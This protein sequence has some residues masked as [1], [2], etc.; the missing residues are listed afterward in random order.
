MLQFWKDLEVT[1]VAEWPNHEGDSTID[2]A[3]RYKLLKT[4][5]VIAGI[6]RPFLQHLVLSCAR[7]GDDANNITARPTVRAL[8]LPDSTHPARNPARNPTRSPAHIPSVTTRLSR[9]IHDQVSTAFL[10]SMPLRTS[11]SPRLSSQNTS[12]L[13][14]LPS[15]LYSSASITLPTALADQQKTLDRS[16]LVRRLLI[17]QRPFECT[18][19]KGHID[20][21]QL[22]RQ[23][24]VHNHTVKIG[25]DLSGLF[26]KDKALQLCRQ[27][28][29]LRC[30]C[31]QHG[32][33]NRR[34]MDMEAQPCTNIC[35]KRSVEHL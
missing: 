25:A 11:S 13:H 5:A 28:S 34:V 26:E 3:F 33:H 32:H 14:D 10:L 18:P 31:G 20:A 17:T 21:V 2:D 22:A 1:P 23:W 7:G 27:S 4:H 30:L 19:S 6:L 12:W 8:S 15:K 16:S 35:S 29:R 24:K 9:A